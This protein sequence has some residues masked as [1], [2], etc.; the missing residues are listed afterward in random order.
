MPG[1]VVVIACSATQNL[2]EGLPE[3]R[4]EDG[5]NDGVQGG[6]EVAQPEEEA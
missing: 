4:A 2:L 5:V 3:L 6:V 1:T